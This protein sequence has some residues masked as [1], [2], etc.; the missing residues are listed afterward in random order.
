MKSARVAAKPLVITA[1]LL[2]VSLAWAQSPVIVESAQGGMNFDCY[3]ETAGKWAQSEAKS[4]A[5]GLSPVSVGSRFVQFAEEPYEGVAEIRPVLPQDGEYR[6]SVTWGASGNANN[7]KYTIEAPPDL[8][9]TVY[10]NQDGWGGGGA[11]NANKWLSL[12]IYKLPAKGAVLRISGEEAT[13]APSSVNNFRMY[14]DAVKFEP[15][16]PG[17]SSETASSSSSAKASAPSEPSAPSAPIAPPFV[18]EQ[19]TTGATS[20]FIVPGNAPQSAPAVAAAPPAQAAAPA[21]A[22]QSGPAMPSSPFPVSGAVAAPAEASAPAV[23]SAAAAPAAPAGALQPASPFAA[24]AAPDSPFSS[25]APAVPAAP[26]QS[27]PAAFSQPVPPGM[28]SMQLGNVAAAPAINASAPGVQQAS[29]P[30]GA[31][32]PAVSDSPFGAPAPPS[33]AQQAPQAGMPGAPAVAAAPAFGAPAPGAASPFGAPQTS[34]SPFGAPQAPQAQL[35]LSQPVVAQNV[36]NSPFEQ[37]STAPSSTQNVFGTAGQTQAASSQAPVFGAP[38]AAAPGTVFTQQPAVSS[39]S[40]FA[41][42]QPGQ[43]QAPGVFAQP[44]QAMPP[45]QPAQ[46]ASVSPFGMPVAPSSSASPFE[47]SAPSGMPAV[48]QAPGMAAAPPA[49]GFG[50]PV[51]GQ[52]QPMQQQPMMQAQPGAPAQPGA[53]AASSLVQAP[54]QPPVQPTVQP[55]AAVAAAPTLSASIWKD[56]D[57]AISEAKKLNRPILLYFASE[58]SQVRKFE[59]QVMGDPRVTE[60]FK[61][62]V[63]ARVPY[64]D[65]AQLIRFYGVDRSPTLIFLGPDGY[66]RARLDGLVTVQKI[67]G[68]TDQFRVR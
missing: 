50:Q 55:P 16:T 38:G 48:A 32:P 45:S 39:A 58:S 61:S 57:T 24:P 21:A 56:Y 44:A 4:R 25:A 63:C 68:V 65:Q 15:A 64:P 2:G 36:S 19:G 59:T 51:F 7:V 52:P 31:P 6:V 18:A 42:M 37:S 29:S 3:S 60:S 12:G 62:F 20:P 34:T 5:E 8:N 26:E 17:M 30:F 54:I 66:T 9:R 13:E 35:P 33:G 46:A 28:T 40:P 1:I 43:V 22:V 23:S 27:A 67:L 14:V 53:Q 47:S 11:A 41:G 49:Q 10:L